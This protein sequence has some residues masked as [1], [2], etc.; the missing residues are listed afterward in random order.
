[1]QCR[2]LQSTHLWVIPIQ[3]WQEVKTSQSDPS[4]NAAERR[5]WLVAPSSVWLLQ[6]QQKKRDQKQPFLLPSTPLGFL[7]ISQCIDTL[8]HAA[9]MRLQLSVHLLFDASSISVRGHWFSSGREDVSPCMD[10]IDNAV[11]NI[12]LRQ[13]AG[14]EGIF[15]RVYGAVIRTLRSLNAQTGREGRVH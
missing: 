9:R 4:L 6:K 11:L 3:C 14:E 10:W 5:S 8:R 7:K 15:R 13:A 2:L 1:M 12:A